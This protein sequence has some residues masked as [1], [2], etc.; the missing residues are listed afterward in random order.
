M[1]DTVNI[2]MN[3]MK[4]LDEKDYMFNLITYGIAP[5]ICGY[6]CST[7]ITLCHRYKNSYNLW[8]EYREE[9]LSQV[10]LKCF[11]LNKT[12]RI[13]TVLFYDENSLYNRIKQK[14]N[15]IFLKS[16]GYDEKESL[17][18]CLFKLRERYMAGCPHEI[19]IF[20]DIP[21]QDVLGFIKNLGRNF[22]YCG[23]WKVYCDVEGVLETFQ[24]YNWSKKKVIELIGQGKNTF[25]I[26]SILDKYKK[27]HL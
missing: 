10:P 2:F 24:R 19:G 8:N 26:I 23:Y 15:K 11:E 7:L 14:E 12:D 6:K 4:S 21:Y 25:E 1:N 16:C 17:V 5:T 20:L 27:H 9:F 13:C 18:N 3:S 22:L